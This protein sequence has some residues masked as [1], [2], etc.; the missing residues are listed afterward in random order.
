[1]LDFCFKKNASNFCLVFIFLAPNF[2]EAYLLSVLERYFVCIPISLRY[3]PHLFYVL[4]LYFPFSIPILKRGYN[5]AD[6]E[7]DYFHTLWIK[8][9][10]MKQIKI[11][12]GE[13]KEKHRFLCLRVFLRWINV[14]FPQIFT[15]PPSLCLLRPLF[16]IKIMDPRMGCISV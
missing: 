4:L 16:L 3:V 13:K 7:V 6:P 14:N 8:K 1:M 11:R 9:N 5:Y 12:R 15:S 10:K 2:D